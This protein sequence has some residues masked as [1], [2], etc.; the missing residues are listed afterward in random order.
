[1]K[2]EEI[3]QEAINRYG[4]DAQIDMMIEE[5]SELTQALLKLR[6]NKFSSDPKY[7]IQVCEEMADVEI[8]TQQMRMIFNTAFIAKFKYEKIIRLKERLAIL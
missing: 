3:L 1:M 8:M 7:I 4:E 2:D 5:M 6:R